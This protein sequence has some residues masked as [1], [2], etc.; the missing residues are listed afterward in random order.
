MPTVSLTS[1]ELRDHYQRQCRVPR[2]RG[3]KRPP[4]VAQSVKSL[5]KGIPAWPVYRLADHVDPWLWSDQHLGHANILRYA[6]RPFPSVKEMDQAF[7]DNWSTYVGDDDLVLFLGDVAMGSEIN[8][9]LFARLRALP[10][11]KLLVPGNHDVKPRGGHLRMH[12]FDQVYSLA[13]ANGDPQLIFTHVPLIDVPEGFVNIHGHTH[14]R[15]PTDTPHINV[16]VEQI[17]YRPVRLSRLRALALSL[18][19][20]QYPEGDTTLERLHSLEGGA[21]GPSSVAGHPA[22]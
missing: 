10:G 18:A 16:A 9:G 3:P 17:D 11:R 22:A 6:S 7:F 21:Q 1:S 13:V 5:A 14:N 20:E 19:A 4:G 8:E 2:D 12:G 15:P